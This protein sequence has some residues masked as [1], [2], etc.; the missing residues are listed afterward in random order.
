MARVASV[1]VLFRD[2]PA[3]AAAFDLLRSGALLFGGGPLGDGWRPLALPAGGLSA[4]VPLGGA[5]APL[6]ELL[7]APALRARWDARAGR[8]PE[9][10]R[11]AAVVLSSSRGAAPRAPG[12]ALAAL[13]ARA[14]G[15]RGA[16][17]AV[18]DSLGFPP[19]AHDDGPLIVDG[20]EGAGGAGGAGGAD[21]GDAALPAAGALKEVVVGATSDGA[22]A[23]ALARARALEAALGAARDARALSAWRLRGC[24]TSLRLL[25]SRY[26]AL[27]LHAGGAL[28]PLAAAVGGGGAAA[29]H[30]ARHGEAGAAQLRV[31]ADA[32]AGL[33]VRFCDYAG[34]RPFFNEAAET[35]TDAMDP[36]L[37]RDPSDPAAQASLACKSIVGMDLVS[38][39]RMRMTGRVS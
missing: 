1:T 7:C 17:R 36:A 6:L 3:L 24:G 4:G 27:V 29:L 28:A 22:L 12:A 31:T 18:L 9:R 26:S 16:V 37:N 35:L 11:L 33:D 23:A 30:G 15:A 34:A 13:A 21:A 10:A 2:A 8:A 19:Q 14:E 32:L 20:D 5:G 25:P 38:T 39:L